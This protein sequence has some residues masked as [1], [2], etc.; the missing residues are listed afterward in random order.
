MLPVGC[1]LRDEM[2]TGIIVSIHLGSSLFR[3]R[4]FSMLFW[5][6]AQYYLCSLPMTSIIVLVNYDALM[7]FRGILHKKIKLLV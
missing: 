6:V 4:A 1:Y 3:Q 7:R 5:D 2:N